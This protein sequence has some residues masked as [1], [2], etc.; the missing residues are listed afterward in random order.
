MFLLFARQMFRGAIFLNS[1]GSNL[2]RHVDTVE[3]SSCHLYFTDKEEIPLIQF[4]FPGTFILWNR[5]PGGCFPITR[6]LIS[7]YLGLI[8]IY[9]TFP[10]NM[11][12]YMYSL[13]GLVSFLFSKPLPWVTLEPCVDRAVL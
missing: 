3:S 2:P 12:F 8:V 10:H 5:L 7:S 6:I 4:F 9:P 1:T 13:Y 11:H